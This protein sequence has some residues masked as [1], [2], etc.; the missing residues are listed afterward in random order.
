VSWYTLWHNTKPEPLMGILKIVV[1]KENVYIPTYELKKND[2]KKVKYAVYPG[3][4]F[5]KSDII[6]SDLEDRL[7]AEKSGIRGFLPAPLVKKTSYGGYVIEERKPWMPLTQKEFKGIQKIERK[8]MAKE[9]YENA[10]SLQ[11]GDRVLIGSSRGNKKGVFPVTGKIV[12]LDFEQGMANV[13]T[14]FFNRNC[15]IFTTLSSLEKL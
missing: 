9:M 15:T 13:E 10:Q 6:D 11:I 14:I 4:V 3:Y 1:G 2:N 7:I 12:S 8:L 5:I